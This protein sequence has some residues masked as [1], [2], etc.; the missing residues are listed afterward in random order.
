VAL[1][2]RYCHGGGAVACHT[3]HQT[4]HRLVPLRGLHCEAWTH[5]CKHV[6][7]RGQ[8]PHPKRQSDPD[9]RTHIPGPGRTYREPDP[10]TP[11]RTHI[12]RPRPTSPNPDLEP[13][14]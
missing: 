4:H 7:R 2:V 8:I 1:L 6:L 13:H 10:H 9:T 12:P 3:L 5:I 14:T 11:T